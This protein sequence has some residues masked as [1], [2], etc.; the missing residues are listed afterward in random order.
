MRM[1]VANKA[2]DTAKKPEEIVRENFMNLGRSLIELMKVY[3]CSG[4]GIVNSVIIVGAEN[5]EK[6][7]TAGRGV[8][9]I[10]GHCGNWELASI[11]VSK[12]IGILGGVARPVDNPWINAVVVGI[13]GRY[14]NSVIYKKGA[15]RDM[16]KMLKSGQSVGVLMDQAVVPQEGIVID[17]LGNPAW[18]TKMPAIMCKRTGSAALPV[19]MHREGKGHVLEILPEVELNGDEIED[20]KRLSA[21]IEEYIRKYP[22][23]WLWIHKRWKRA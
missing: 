16:L 5:Y 19:F 10:T 17:F 21:T 18:T 4:D 7:R 23:E 22:E 14:G 3:Y 6:A 2:I 9:Y 13:R 12:Q 1:A 20:T 15:L 11:A 8:M